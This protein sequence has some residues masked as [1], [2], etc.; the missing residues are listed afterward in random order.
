MPTHCSSV[1]GAF[2]SRLQARQLQI[3]EMDG[4][5]FG[6]A[7]QVTGKV[8]IGLCTIA[9]ESC[10]SENRPIRYVGLM[11]HWKLNALSLYLE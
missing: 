5:T 10:V 4:W 1:T 2:G 11:V 6:D 7:L 3:E 9:E 8:T